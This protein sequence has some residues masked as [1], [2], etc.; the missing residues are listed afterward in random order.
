[1][2]SPTWEEDYAKKYIKLLKI[3]DSIQE[4]KSFFC[5]CFLDIVRGSKDKIHKSRLLTII[6][7]NIKG[8]AP[9]RTKTFI[10]LLL[11]CKT[12]SN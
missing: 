10:I 9:P 4:R 12:T 7:P 8:D 6:N 3:L 11:M 1:M 2:Y 5:E